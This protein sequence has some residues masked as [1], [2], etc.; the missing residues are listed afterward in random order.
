MTYRMFTGQ[1]HSFA[2]GI[3]VTATIALAA[4]LALSPVATAQTSHRAGASSR[5]NQPLEVNAPV[6]TLH[7][8][9][10]GGKLECTR[11]IVPLDY[12]DPTGDTIK[13]A[14]SRLPATDQA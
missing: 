4:S 11:A 12:D 7:W 5:A 8:H 3:A 2:T 1:R 13:L 14:I 9:S 6:P 10:C